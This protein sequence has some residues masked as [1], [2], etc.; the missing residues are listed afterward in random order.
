MVGL[1]NKQQVKE[2]MKSLNDEVPVP[3]EQA[4]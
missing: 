3:Q 2:A 4:L 1:L